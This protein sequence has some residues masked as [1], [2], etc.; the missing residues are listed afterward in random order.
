M[1][2]KPVFEAEEAVELSMTPT[3]I[4]AELQ[5]SNPARKVYQP[6]AEWVEV[7]FGRQVFQF[8]PDLPGAPL[9]AHPALRD[10]NGKPLMVPANGTLDVRDN[11]GPAFD[12][13]T[14]SFLRG[15]RPVQGE[16]ADDF[17]KHVANTTKLRATGFTWLRQDGKDEQ[18]KKEAKRIYQLARRTWAEQEIQARAEAIANFNKLPQNQGQ[19]P[20]PPTQNQI[21]AQEFLDELKAGKRTGSEF[22][23]KHGCYET[24]DFTKY[25][26]HMQVN[27]AESI[28]AVDEMGASVEVP[29]EK[30]KPGRPKKAEAAA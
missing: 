27:H 13:K 14:R 9:V 22:V 10:G 8:P 24:S 11:F 18:R 16:S 7:S 17:L 30:R 12:P 4:A 6:A 28:S 20:P 15:N 25:Q 5:R 26:R 1:N 21:E 29:A 2:L 3:D 23:C 19:T